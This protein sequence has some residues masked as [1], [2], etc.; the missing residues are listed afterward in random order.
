MVSVMTSVTM[1]G[2]VQQRTWDLEVMDLC[3]CA[4]AGT[5]KTSKGMGDPVGFP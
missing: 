1:L 3:G 5:S 4:Q 2:G